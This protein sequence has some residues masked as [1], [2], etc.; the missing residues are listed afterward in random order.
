MVNSLKASLKSEDG[1]QKPRLIQLT[2]DYLPSAYTKS[3]NLEM[4]PLLSTITL[5]DVR[6]AAV[7]IILNM[8]A[9]RTAEACVH[10]EAQRH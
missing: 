10:S 9:P 3:P 5:R 4:W 2:R 6:K 8:M 1:I 7:N